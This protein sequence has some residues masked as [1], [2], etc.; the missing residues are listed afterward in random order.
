M[1]DIKQ[2]FQCAKVVMD[3]AGYADI[4]RWLGEGWLIAW[5][6]TKEKENT[7]I[8]FFGRDLPA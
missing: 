2:E 6:I 1:A 5:V 7:A 3:D 4:V 8:V